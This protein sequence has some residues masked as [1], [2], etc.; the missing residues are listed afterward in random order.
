MHHCPV[1][2]QR[3]LQLEAAL[4]ATCRVITYV[5]DVWS[6]WVFEGEQLIEAGHAEYL[7]WRH[8]EHSGDLVCAAFADP[9]HGITQG[10]EDR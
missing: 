2:C 7:S 8:L 3:V 1:G 9:A 6:A 5:Q 10:V 4:D